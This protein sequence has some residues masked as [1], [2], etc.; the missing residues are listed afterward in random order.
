MFFEKKQEETKKKQTGNPFGSSSDEDEIQIPDTGA[1]L[2]DLDALIEKEK[3]KNKNKVSFA[4]LFGSAIEESK[5]KG[6]FCGC[7]GE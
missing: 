5:S 1:V 2:D 7:F 3:N 4:N 6:E